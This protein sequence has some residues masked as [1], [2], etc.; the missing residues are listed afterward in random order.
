MSTS[1]T[2]G[3]SCKVGSSTSNKFLTES[4]NELRA[5]PE[6]AVTIVVVDLREQFDIQHYS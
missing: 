2:G 5:L 3:V 6:S 1:P 4:S